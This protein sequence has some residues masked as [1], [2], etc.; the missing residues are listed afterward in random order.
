MKTK[1]VQDMGQVQARV[2]QHAGPARLHCPWTPHADAC[3][4]AFMVLDGT[5]VR[6]A[7]S[8]LKRMIFH[9]G[10]TRPFHVYMGM[11]SGMCVWYDTTCT[12]VRRLSDVASGSCALK[13][14]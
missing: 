5:R 7:I 13:S 8:T 3:V 4:L 6:S 11:Y 14:T 10:S 2:N 9:M 1:T 12:Q